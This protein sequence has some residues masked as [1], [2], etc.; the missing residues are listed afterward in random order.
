MVLSAIGLFI[1]GFLTLAH[2]SNLIVPCSEGGGCMEVT[3]HAS[4]MLGPFPVALLGFLGYFALATLA[5]VRSGAKAEVWK[6]T[7]LVGLLLSGAGAGFSGYLQYVSYTQIEQMCDWCMASALVMVLLFLAHGLL[8]QYP[9]PARDE[10]RGTPDL[11]IGAVAMLVG[12]GASAVMSTSVERAASRPIDSVVIETEV[13]LLPSDAKMI[14]PADAPVTII[15]FADINCGACRTVYPMLKEILRANP[16]NL[17]IGFRH[18]PLFELQG[19]ETSPQAHTLAELAAEE[20]KFWEYM[21]AAFSPA[22][23]TAVRSAD[24]LL[25]LGTQVGLEREAVQA[26]LTLSKENPYFNSM[27][28][29]FEA[30]KGIGIASTPTFIIMHEGHEPYAVGP[31]GLKE[32]LMSGHLRGVLKTPSSDPADVA[33][34]HHPGDGHNH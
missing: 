9:V 1:A 20:G 3:A 14:G 22:N 33:G 29:D 15:E 16:E 27:S 2:Y 4:S 17:R 12:L 7:A 31:Q 26:A 32:A 8:A 25:R 21:D 10:K 13:D 30:A 34:G 18:Y 28:T 6:K 23:E 5:I 24:G 19:H 11:A